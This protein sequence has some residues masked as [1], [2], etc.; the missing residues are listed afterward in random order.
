MRTRVCVCVFVCVRICASVRVRACVRACVYAFNCVFDSSYVYV[1]ACVC[2]CARVCVFVCVFVCVRAR[3]CRKWTFA[4]TR[5]STITY[6]K[7]SNTG[8][9]EE[10]GGRDRQPMG[11]H[12]RLPP[13]ACIDKTKQNK[14]QRGTWQFLSSKA[15]VSLRQSKG[16][17]LGLH[18]G[19][20][21]NSNILIG[22]KICFQTKCNN[23]FSTGRVL[24]S[25]RV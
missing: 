5:G 3:A 18:Y 8:R 7:R 6:L 14:T 15:P 24:G 13:P 22:T 4:T 16:R 2:V 1:H 21:N 19:N 17:I 10:G 11:R 9:R 20:P 12:R 25:L 23:F